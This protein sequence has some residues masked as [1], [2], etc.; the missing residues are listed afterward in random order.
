MVVKIKVKTRKILRAKE[1]GYLLCYE[2]LKILE[3]KRGNMKKEMDLYW[4]RWGVGVP[5]SPIFSP[6]TG[7]VFP[8]I[9][10]PDLICIELERTVTFQFL[11][12]QPPTAWHVFFP[13]PLILKLPLEDKVFK[14]LE[15]IFGRNMEYI[16]SKIPSTWS[17]LGGR[18]Q[19]LGGQLWGPKILP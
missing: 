6:K 15:E 4:Q 11:H 14:H 5:H 9:T 1:R 3:V 2:V 18:A 7:D 10:A 13:Q 12:T 16:L 19:M 8:S 17:Q